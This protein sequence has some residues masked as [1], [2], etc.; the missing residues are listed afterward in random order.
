MCL[1]KL[2]YISYK[3]K[4]IYLNTFIIQVNI[5][6]YSYPSLATDIFK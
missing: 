3:S 2:I 1:Y 5:E 6:V 4:C